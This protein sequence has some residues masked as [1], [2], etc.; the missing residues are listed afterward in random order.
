MAYTKMETEADA[1]YL[2]E[3][4]FKR[5]LLEVPHVKLWSTY[6]D[7][8]R[9]TNNM[10]TD[11]TGNA[12]KIVLQAFDFVLKNVGMDREAGYLWQDYIN[13][14]KSG[15]GTIGGTGWQD[16]QKMDDLRKAY[17]RAVVVPTRATNTIWLEYSGFEN[18]L[19]KI[20][21]SFTPQLEE[22]AT[23]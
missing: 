5:C 21:V 16:A 20:T 2:V 19:N 3:Q 14:I 22:I 6:L 12:R 17:Q 13:F 1:M 23:C 4:I 11:T 8:V 15:P 7:Y 18:N 10:N 9:R